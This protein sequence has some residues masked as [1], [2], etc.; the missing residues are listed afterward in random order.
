MLKK[1]ML[2]AFAVVMSISIAGCGPT[3]KE[4]AENNAARANAKITEMDEV[5][6]LLFY[7]GVYVYER[8]GYE[9]SSHAKSI[10]KLDAMSS[11]DR[12]L[13]IERL[14]KFADLANEAIA[15]GSAENV[16]LRGKETIAG[17]AKLAA[18]LASEAREIQSRKN[19]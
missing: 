11:E 9:G 3:V 6:Q 7:E 8:A 2:A 13:T 16:Q 1:L 17:A 4:K 19:D 18:K 14:T 12:A 5:A 10:N 15:Y